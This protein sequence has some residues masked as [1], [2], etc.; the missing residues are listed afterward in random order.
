MKQKDVREALR[1]AVHSG[2]DAWLC[3]ATAA[4]KLQIGGVVISAPNRLKVR[5]VDEEFKPHTYNILIE[6]A[7]R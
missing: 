7:T 3:Q 6:E 4:K 5:M 2:I 1:A